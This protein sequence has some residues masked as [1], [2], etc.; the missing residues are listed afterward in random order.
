MILKLGIKSDK[1]LKE[2]FIWFIIKQIK[3]KIYS[4]ILCDE[5]FGQELHKIKQLNY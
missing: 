2:S 1:A 5:S 4:R 3:V